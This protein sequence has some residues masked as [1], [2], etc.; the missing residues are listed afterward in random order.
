MDYVDLLTTKLSR[1]G[2]R[3]VETLPNLAAAVCIFLVFWLFAKVG[4]KV[5]LQALHGVSDNQ[6]VTN[7]LA[8]MFKVAILT[9]GFFIALR[10]LELDGAVTSLLAGVGILGLAL[11]FAFQDIAANFISGVILAVLRPFHVG[12]IVSTNGF[13]GTIQE[14]N[15]RATIGLNF[16]GQIVTL[17]N[18]DVLQDK[19]KN[20]TRSN[21][22]RVD[23]EVRVSFGDNLD[24]VENVVVEA[25]RDLERD[26]RRDIEFYYESFGLSSINF[27]LRIWIHPDQQG[28]LRTRHDAIKRIQRAFH[29]KGLTI[30]FPIQTLNFGKVGG[31]QLEEVLPE[32]LAGEKGA[33]ESS[34]R[35]ENS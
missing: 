35:S 28:F 23:I 3:A 27:R 16:E 19:I 32:S 30:P 6:A 31:A 4:R 34:V 7:L 24:E 29:D 13:M 8:G 9:T 26:E 20:Y 21:E 5:A 1:W 18:K 11:G 2:E 15:L 10:V 25:V 17:P 22:R 33:A 12:D 14:I